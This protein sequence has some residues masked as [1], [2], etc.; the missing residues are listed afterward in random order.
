MKSAVITIG[1]ICLCA[2]IASAQTVNDAL[3]PADYPI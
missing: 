1:A 3:K 2:A